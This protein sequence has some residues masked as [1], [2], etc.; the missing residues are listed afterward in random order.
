MPGVI[1][2]NVD[3]I[4]D[5]DTH[6]YLGTRTSVIRNGKEVAGVG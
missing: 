2:G 6:V 5:R 4:F 3:F 1:G